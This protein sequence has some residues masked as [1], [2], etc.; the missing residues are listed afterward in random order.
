MQLP[1]PLPEAQ[2]ADKVHDR[3]QQEILLHPRA[4]LHAIHGVAAPANQET[5]LGIR[6][7]KV[8]FEQNERIVQ[9]LHGID[10]DILPGETVGIV[11]ESGCGKSTTA[12]MVLGLLAPSQ[13][14][15]RFEGNEVPHRRTA[16]WRAL[17]KRMQMIYQ[18]PLA[19]LDRRLPIIDQVIEPLTVQGNGSREF[20]YRKA[21]NS[22]EAVGLMPHMFD[23]YPHELSGG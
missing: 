9:A 15:I 17:R 7:L 11:G 13:G 19:V 22:L 8:A 14:N 20:N 23:R 3:R 18:D 21:A 12:K 4:G 16:Q 5:I 2:A 10:L 1:L 6:N